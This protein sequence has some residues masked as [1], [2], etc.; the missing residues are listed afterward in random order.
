[1]FGEPDEAV[2]EVV[3]VD[4]GDPVAC[5]GELA[6]VGLPDVAQRVEAVVTK[7]IGGSPAKLAAFIGVKGWA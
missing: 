1:M 3:L 2:R 4:I 7:G 6:R 5:R